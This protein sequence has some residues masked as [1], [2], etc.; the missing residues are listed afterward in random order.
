M[1][2]DETGIDKGAFLARVA[3]RKAKQAADKDADLS[4]FVGYTTGNQAPQSA[5]A[6]P[7][8]QPP[9]I[10]PIKGLNGTQSVTTDI[11]PALARQLEADAAE[12]FEDFHTEKSE[13]DRAIDE[14]IS[15]LDVIEAYR[16]WIRKMEPQRQNGQTE[17]IMISC[18][19]PGHVDERPSAWINTEKGEGGL[20]HCAGCARGGDKYDLAAI[21]LGYDPFGYKTDGSFRNLK[22][23]MARQLGVDVDK[24]LLGPEARAYIAASR[25]ANEQTESVVTSAPVEPAAPKPTVPRPSKPRDAQTS[26][27][28]ALAAM[29]AG[30][31]KDWDERLHKYYPSKEEATPEPPTPPVMMPIGLIPNQTAESPSTSQP[32]GEIQDVAGLTK[33]MPKPAVG[34][35]GA[36]PSFSGLGLPPVTSV[37]TAPPTTAQ[38]SF[39]LPGLAMPM[40]NGSIFVTQA[41]PQIDMNDPGLVKAMLADQGIRTD[42]IED[43]DDG[44]SFA[45]L[46]FRLLVPEDTFLGIYCAI[47][48]E[49]DSPDEWNFWNAMAGLSVAVGKRIGMADRKRVFA[50]LYIC[51]LGETTAGKSIAKSYLTKL[52]KRSLPWV[53]NDPGNTAP[54]IIRGTASGEYL[55]TKF[56]DEIRDPAKPGSVLQVK[57]VSG[58]VE[59][60]E[61]ATVMAKSNS[62]T[63]TFVTTLQALFD[64]YEDVESGSFTT[65]DK[66]APDPFATLLTS[67]QPSMMQRLVGREHVDN[68]FLNRFIF[69]PATPKEQTPEDMLGGSFINLNPAVPYLRGVHEWA[70][71]NDGEDMTFT[72]RALQLGRDFLRDQVVADKK[73]H[74]E[75]KLIQR[76]DLLAKKLMLLFAL[77][78]KSPVV[79]LEAVESVIKVYPYLMDSYSILDRSLTA[80]ESSELR[81]KILIQIGRLT[82]KNNKPPSKREIHD[83]LGRSK[84]DGEVLVRAL[85]NLT[86]LGDVRELSWP[87]P[88]MPQVGR[89]SVRYGLASED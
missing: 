59:Y 7:R 76:S 85:K 48:L 38:P 6:S 15:R 4:S 13:L 18:P 20:W 14:V 8:R 11:S 39:G 17:S 75:N 54:R 50:N 68:G 22:Q 34:G 19:I 56:R 86:E 77:N 88:G 49:S 71:E 72:P 12:M 1:T 67:T 52:L 78:M 32:E 79:P 51:L 63:S 30:A 70:V 36:M 27:E 33:D 40:P 25:V 57:R 87:L 66:L 29:H 9:R 53:A 23:D 64:G 65:G 24:Y 43:D 55:I 28:T 31:S 82:T 62:P 80:T 5:V 45:S 26:N 89:K 58:L 10:P 44:N 69:A 35:K 41:V 21:G 61:F 3:E 83:A 74:S 46:D 47:L 16:L 84:V 81:N 60:D 42:D 37:P 2:D 73:N